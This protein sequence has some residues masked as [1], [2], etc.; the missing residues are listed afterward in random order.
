MKNLILSAALV[1]SLCANGQLQKG[2]SLIGGNV[3]FYLTRHESLPINGTSSS[4]EGFSFNGLVRYGYFICNNLAAGIQYNYY[5]NHNKE[6]YRNP[7]NSQTQKSIS[8]ANSPGI[9][10]RGYKPAMNGKL[11]F[12]GDLSGYYSWGHGDNTSENVVPPVPAGNNFHNEMLG[13]GISF[14]PGIV[15]FITNKIGIETKLGALSYIISKTSNFQ[16]G[17]KVNDEKTSTMAVN[18]SYTS[19][20]IGAHYYFG[21]KKEVSPE[22][23]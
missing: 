21:G 12:F 11:A 18:L 4:S 2:S 14:S 9:F 10:L 3:S 17:R 8:K 5:L 7:F 22:A 6:T 16:G 13:M 20:F 19:F 15:Y 23:K 1:L